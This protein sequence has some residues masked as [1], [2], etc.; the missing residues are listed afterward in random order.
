[1]PELEFVS[2]SETQLVLSSVFSNQ[3]LFGQI[4]TCSDC[5]VLWSRNMVI[6]PTLSPNLRYFCLCF[7]K[8]FCWIRAKNAALST[9]AS[10]WDC[11]C[12]CCSCFSP[13]MKC[14]TNMVS[15][16]CGLWMAAAYLISS[17]SFCSTACA[18]S[19]QE[20]NPF[21]RVYTRNH[22]A[23]FSYICNGANMTHTISWTW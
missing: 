19:S 18:N 23:A 17:N 16:S 6:G 22:H 15:S 3:F 12:P 14:A 20:L 5:L 11:T 9:V 7:S 8:T 1:M 10:T 4:L 21:R 13:L 2:T